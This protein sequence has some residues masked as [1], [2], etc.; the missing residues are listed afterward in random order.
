MPCCVWCC[1]IKTWDIL[2]SILDQQLRLRQ[3]AVGPKG[4]SNR[5]ACLKIYGEN[6]WHNRQ[7]ECLESWWYRPKK[8]FASIGRFLVIFCDSRGCG[9]RDYIVLNKISKVKTEEN[10]I[11]PK[12]QRQA[13]VSAWGCVCGVLCL[14]VVVGMSAF[15]ELCHVVVGIDSVSENLAL[16]QY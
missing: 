7:R 11:F 15:N 12:I 13:K 16:Y 14:P 6:W 4:E 8:V 3:M 1:L 2:W 9:C 10:L 5:E